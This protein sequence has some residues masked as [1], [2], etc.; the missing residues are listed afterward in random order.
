MPP[1]GFEY[2]WIDSLDLNL[3]KNGPTLESLLE[4]VV[5]KRKSYQNRNKGGSEFCVV[6]GISNGPLANRGTLCI[7]CGVCLSAF[8]CLEAFG[9]VFSQDSASVSGPS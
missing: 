2:A 3:L 4:D 9:V 6:G 8:L 1:K 5:S 7:V